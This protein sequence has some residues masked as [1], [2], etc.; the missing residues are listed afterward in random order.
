[1]PLDKIDIEILKTLSDDGNPSSKHIADVTDIP[2]STVHY[3]L[4]KLKEDGVIENDLYEL[5]SDELGFTVRIIS[6]VNANYEEGY[7]DRVGDQLRSI[8][9]VSQVYFTLGDTDFIVIANLPDSS[10]VERL[11]QEYEAIKGVVRTNSTL[12]ISTIKADNNPLQSYD[13]DT[14]EGLDL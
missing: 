2:K 5:D 8:E 6:E 7:H 9:G 4:D 12:V 10:H 1:M 14:L 13:L 11:I 3:R